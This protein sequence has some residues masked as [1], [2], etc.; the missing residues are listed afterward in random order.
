LPSW[1]TKVLI[2][3][4]V[5]T[6]L[7]SVASFVRTII[8][9]F[10]TAG[11]IG[12]AQAATTTSAATTAAA[13]GTAGVTALAQGTAQ[14]AESIVFSYRDQAADFARNTIDPNLSQGRVPTTF[15]NLADDR[16]KV[17]IQADINSGRLPSTYRVTPRGV[18]GPD[19]FDTATGIGY[20]LT[21]AT[22]LQV[23]KHD[24]KYI[25]QIVNFDGIPYLIR[26][27]LPLVYS[28]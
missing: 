1:L 17:L 5:I 16:F 25:G 23:W 10:R 4:L 20:D 27:V 8:T 22:E 24:V 7:L 19:V 2:A 26:D 6:A 9:G 18:F 21:T 15:G 14:T 11:L 12:A 13:G 28:R 3:G